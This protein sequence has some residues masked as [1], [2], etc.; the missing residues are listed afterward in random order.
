MCAGVQTQ[1][2]KSCLR[3]LYNRVYLDAQ[4]QASRHR[5]SALPLFSRANA[6]PWCF[7]AHESA[8][9]VFVSRACYIQSDSATVTVEYRVYLVM[10]RPLR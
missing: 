5:E 6:Y 3:P 9:L 2:V 4:S 7:A 10:F 1:R 8:L